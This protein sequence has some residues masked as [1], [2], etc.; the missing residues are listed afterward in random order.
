MHIYGFLANTATV[1][2][3]TAIGLLAGSRL[4][5][6]IKKI[7]FMGLGLST[8]VIGAQMALGT[9]NLFLVVGSTI[10]GGIIG[11]LIG[12]EE[13][14]ERIGERLKKKV[15]SSS[16]TFVLGF[17]TASLLFCTGPMTIV[18]SLED[19]FA[20]KADLIY[21]KSLLDGAAAIAL[22]ASLGI[23]VIFSALTVLIVQGL[24]T[25]LGEAMGNFISEVVLNEISAAGGLLI[26]G[27]GFNMLTNARIPV[28][29]FL[30][31]LGVIAIT[32]WLII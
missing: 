30:P 28:G 21:I 7:I 23:G 5:E 18:G 19:G 3:G 2:L 12:I 11:Q 31:A 1:I 32:A 16:S 6:K 22:T 9:K 20:Q 8:I 13:W 27:I 10:I 4:P 25:G 14:L 29:N 24:L 26:M 15:G 17:V